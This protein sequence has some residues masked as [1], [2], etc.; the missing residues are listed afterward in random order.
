MTVVPLNAYKKS[1]PITFHTLAM[2]GVDD[3]FA[4][5]DKRMSIPDEDVDEYIKTRL[6]ASGKN[7]YAFRCHQPWL[8]VSLTGTQQ[9]IS[10]G[11]FHRIRRQ[12]GFFQGCRITRTPS[13]QQP[14][15]PRR[16]TGMQATRGR[17]FI[18]SRAALS[19]K[20][21][22]TVSVNYFNERS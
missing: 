7:R 19:G 4:E 21:A 22:E 5:Q 14:P 10:T 9:Q 2:R 17:R 15:V 1:Q 12:I 6:T 11:T 3:F 13:S 8:A 18:R 16:S 20:L